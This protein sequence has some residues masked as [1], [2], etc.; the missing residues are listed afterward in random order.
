M[1]LCTDCEAPVNWVKQDE[2][3]DGWVML[4]RAGTSIRIVGSDEHPPYMKWTD[5][6]VIHSCDPRVL[7]D[8]ILKAETGKPS[9]QIAEEFYDMQDA[10]E[11]AIAACVTM[12]CPKCGVAADEPCENL[13]ERKR[14]NR[15]PTVSPHEDRIN[16][17]M[18]T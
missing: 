10:R 8:R 4:S 5:T 17:L 2:R 7:A 11:K 18:E 9:Y 6:Y 1:R 3:K 16:L 15:K 12:A 14:G 13:S